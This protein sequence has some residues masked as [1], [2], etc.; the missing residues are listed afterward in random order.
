MGVVTVG[1]TEYDICSVD[2]CTHEVI[3]Y[4]WPRPPK[5]T[6][7]FII[8]PTW[9][10]TCMNKLSCLYN[11]L[12][13]YGTFGAILTRTLNSSQDVVCINGACMVDW[14]WETKIFYMLISTQICITLCLI[15]FIIR[16]WCFRSHKPR[17]D[18]LYSAIASP[19]N[20]NE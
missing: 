5:Y 1:Y 3:F 14:W 16:C 17:Y 8:P 2:V 10:V 19:L 11:T 13:P 6:T 18:S 15:Y 9:S 4:T 12:D 20:E 7:S